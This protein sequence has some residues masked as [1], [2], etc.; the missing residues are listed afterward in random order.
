MP[1]KSNALSRFTEER[2]Q[3]N[4]TT[5]RQP[6]ARLVGPSWSRLSRLRLSVHLCF[7]ANVSPSRYS[8]RLRQGKTSGRARK[9]GPSVDCVNPKSDLQ[10]RNRTY[11]CVDKRKAPGAVLGASPNRT[12]SVASVVGIR[13]GNATNVEIDG[14]A[15]GRPLF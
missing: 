14:A 6:T 2:D 8:L 3:W 4:A 13:D 15:R 12:Y 10:S 1:A 11:R 7:D 9:R 5:K